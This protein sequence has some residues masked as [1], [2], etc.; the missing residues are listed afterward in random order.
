M[1]A[2]VTGAAGFMGSHLCDYLLARGH[3]VIGI[4]NMLGGDVE[5]LHDALNDGML[6]VQADCCD[7]ERMTEELH[8]CEVVYHL[9]A[10][11]HEGLSVFSPCVVTRHTHLSSVAVGTAAVRNKVKRFVFVSSMSRYGNGKEIQDDNS[12]IFVPFIEGMLPNPVDPYGIA[13]VASEQVLTV[14]GEQHG[15]EVVTAVPHNVVGS[16]QRY[17]D[18]YRNVLAIMVNLLL[19]GRQPYIYGDGNQVRC[20]TD[21]DDCTSLIA[22]LGWEPDLDGEVFNVGPDDQ[23]ATIGRVCQMLCEKLGVKYDPIFLPERP[24][25]VKCAYPSCLKAR[26]R[27]GYE[28]KV[29]LSETLDKIIAWVK[30]GPKPFEYHLP[31][32]ICTEKTPKT[33]AEK[34]M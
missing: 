23:A 20:F 9:A 32:E 15:M 34:L 11:P 26:R 29:T 16:R 33:W 18:P 14:L 31:L 24:A 17:T 4:D 30:Q 10:A 21:I 19:Q 1:Y 25:E 12:G 28:L 5:N 27:L 6:F 7:L 8:G 3:R 22:R 2:A 13:K